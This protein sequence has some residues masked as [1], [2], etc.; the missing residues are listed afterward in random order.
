MAQF[1]KELK[2]LR[3]SKEISLEDLESKTKINI[4]YLKAIEEGDFNVLPTP[5]LRLFIRAYAIEIGGEADRALD[6]LDS[7]VGNKKPS[8][9]ASIKKTDKE[10][11]ELFD[12]SSISS[13]LSN[14]NLKLRKDL[15]KVSMVS[16]LFVFSIFI[17]KKI[18]SNESS[19]INQLSPQ[20]NQKQIKIISEAQL[21]TDYNEDKFIEK[22]LNI[23]PPFFFSINTDNQIGIIVTQDTLKPYRKFLY[24]GSELDLEGFIETAQII[25]TNTEKVKAR[26]NGVD[27][28][29]I[30]NYPH[31]LKLTIRSSPPSITVRLYT[32]LN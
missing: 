7:F 8:V 14:S 23:E 16:I 6:Q 18:F 2:E 13:L 29:L 20:L 1:Y 32:P 10:N 5:Y 22:S 9:S 24:P 26:L 30:E 3:V 28:S 31:P 4:K 21:L 17:V 12:N 19:T 27:L 15:L 25:F 11:D